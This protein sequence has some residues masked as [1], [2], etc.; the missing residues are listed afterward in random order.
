LRALKQFKTGS[1]SN[2]GG[3]ST[4]S[5]PDQQL[6]IKQDVDD[7]HQHLLNHQ[8]VMNIKSNSESAN[9]DFDEEYGTENNDLEDESQES[10]QRQA[11]LR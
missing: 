1:A 4:S 8:D 7:T 2:T 6:D 11:L 10:S 9:D 5:V 3:Q